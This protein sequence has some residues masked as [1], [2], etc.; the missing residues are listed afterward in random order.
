[1]AGKRN[2]MLEGCPTMTGAGV[3]DTV[4]L[5]KTVTGR[6]PWDDAKGF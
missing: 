3:A 4:S 5:E 2:E 1:M 6:H